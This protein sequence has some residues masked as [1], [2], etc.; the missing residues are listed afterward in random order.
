M[1]VDGVP[2]TVALYQKLSATWIAQT[3]SVVA[4]LGTADALE[5]GPKGIDELA[6]AATAHAPS[7]YRV[8]RALASVG[9]FAEDEDGRFRLTPLAEPLRSD[10]PGSLRSFAVMLGEEWNWRP[11]EH[12]L[13]SVRTGQ[14]RS[15]TPMG[16][17]SSSTWPSIRKRARS[18]TRP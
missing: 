13:H 3:I 12:L 14:A 15:C 11:W 7:L 9:I 16:R 5:G 4:K 17:A 2:P 10:A 8:L 6:A 18:S 1:Q